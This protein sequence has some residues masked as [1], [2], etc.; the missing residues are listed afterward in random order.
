M[1]TDL[2]ILIDLQRLDTTIAG[3]EAELRGLP[4]KIAQLEN[5]LSE[6][7]QLVESYRKGLADNQ[8]ARRKRETDIAALRDKISHYRDQTLAVKTNEQYRALLHEIE[9]H[10]EQI[11]KLEDAI[12][13]EMIESEA[14]EKKLHEAARSLAEERTR[15][16]A[17]IAQARERHQQDEQA[18]HATRARRAE[19]QGRLTPDIYAQYQRV[20]QFRMGVGVAEV[21]NGACGGCH[22]RLRPQVYAEVL[23]NEHI[24]RCESCSRVLYY[25][26]EPATQ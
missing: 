1:N 15:I 10:E 25:V 22:V 4:L 5:Q 19:V 11:R 6:H 3:L 2:E 21:R 17:E 7:V 24:L 13:A 20:A 16:E 23:T 9:Y 26:P 8:R 18:L 12:L 14:L